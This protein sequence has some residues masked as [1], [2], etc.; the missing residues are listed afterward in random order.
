MQEVLNSCRHN[1]VCKMAIERL[2]PVINY[3]CDYNLLDMNFDPKSKKNVI[4]YWCIQRMK[5]KDYS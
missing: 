2:N 1:K 3:V 4:P 5:N